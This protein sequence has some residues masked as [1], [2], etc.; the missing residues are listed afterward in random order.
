MIEIMK[1]ILGVVAMQG[2]RRV[3]PRG[4][5]DAFHSKAMLRSTPKKGLSVRAST[6]SRIRHTP[7][8]LTRYT[9]AD[10]YHYSLY[11]DLT[12]INYWASESECWRGTPDPV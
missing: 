7:N 2:A 9:G 10:S 1:G 8:R 11:P 12:R 6:C 5:R 3:A 4:R